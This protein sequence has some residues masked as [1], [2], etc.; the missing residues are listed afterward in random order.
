MRR[1]ILP[2][3]MIFQETDQDDLRNHNIRN[4]DFDDL[5]ATCEFSI[6]EKSQVMN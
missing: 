2:G 6:L 3:N 4:T 1:D 5:F